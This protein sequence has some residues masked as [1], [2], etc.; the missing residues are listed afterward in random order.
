MKPLHQLFLSSRKLVELGVMN[1]RLY[2]F[3]ISSIFLTLYSLFSAYLTSMAGLRVGELIALKWEDIDLEIG[4]VTIRRAFVKSME[5]FR[6]YPKGGKHHTHSIPQEVLEKLQV[7]F[8]KRESEWVVTTNRGNHLSYRWYFFAL[9]K[10]CEELELPEI[11]THGLRHSTS[12]LYIHHGATRDDLRRLFAHSSPQVTDRYVHD[13]GTNLE[14]VANVIQLFDRSDLKSTM[15][16][17]HAEV[18][19][20]KGE[21]K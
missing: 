1:S 15:K 10:Y 13:R 5:I 3:R 20:R 16:I 4:R 14:K 21:R 7:A 17:D 8:A 19:H 6:D 11:G 9:K 18:I 12:E 2:F